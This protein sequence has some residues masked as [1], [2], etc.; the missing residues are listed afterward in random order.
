[1]SFC[2]TWIVR[3]IM[4]LCNFCRQVN[5]TFF[6]LK[7]SNIS[8]KLCE[9]RRRSE[10]R[11]AFHF[12]FSINTEYPEKI[13]VCESCTT[14]QHAARMNDKRYIYIKKKSF[15]YETM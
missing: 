13:R 3:F 4:T 8:A 1:M 9:S 14:D 12:L 6:L 15:C 5:L 2:L 10:T 11:P 7:I